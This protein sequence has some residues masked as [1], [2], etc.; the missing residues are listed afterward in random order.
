MR[1][2]SSSQYFRDVY[3]VYNFTLT[4]IMQNFYI[5]GKRVLEMLINLTFV[6]QLVNSQMGIWTQLCLVTDLCFSS[7]YCS[8]SMEPYNIVNIC[9][10]Q[11][12][13]CCSVLSSLYIIFMFIVQYFHL[14]LGL[15]KL[16]TVMV[17]T[18]QSHF[19]TFHVSHKTLSVMYLIHS[20]L[21][22]LLNNT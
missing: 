14:F 22:I 9:I 8:V 21:F 3:I 15:C 19:L 17:Q 6:S 10:H 20:N 12:I 7:I 11:F 2:Y 13:T 4:T 5:M 18:S 16:S 1:I